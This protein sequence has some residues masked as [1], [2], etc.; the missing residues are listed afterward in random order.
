MVAV[1]IV[2]LCCASVGGDGEISVPPRPAEAPL[3]L[4]IVAAN[5]PVECGISADFFLP[6]DSGTN[7]PV[8]MPVLAC[9][10]TVDDIGHIQVFR[11]GDRKRIV[12]AIDLSP[13]TMTPCVL[14]GL[15]VAETLKSSELTVRG[16]GRILD[17]MLTGERDIVHSLEGDGDGGSVLCLGSDGMALVSPER[18]ADTID[19]GTMLGDGEIRFL[20]VG[21]PWD[22][23]GLR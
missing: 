22:S 13:E 4:A 1:A 3:S 15:C 19:V 18:L 6:A 14:D 21:D 5:F 8:P 20:M 17:D 12:T 2:L 11:S 9:D 7:Y 16:S 10:L 23:H